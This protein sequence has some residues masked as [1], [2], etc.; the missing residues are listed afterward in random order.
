VN[1]GGH[2]SYCSHKAESTGV[3]AHRMSLSWSRII[4]NGGRDEPVNQAGVD[5]YRRVIQGLLDAGIV[6]SP[7]HVFWLQLTPR[8]LSSYV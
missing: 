5:F 8:L 3:N 2:W 7:N 6:S 4:P 1:T